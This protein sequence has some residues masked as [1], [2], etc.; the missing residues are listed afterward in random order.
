VVEKKWF[1]YGT[2][3]CKSGAQAPHSKVL[4]AWLK[5]GTYLGEAKRGYL[6][7]PRSK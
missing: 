5:P 7:M 6:D 3:N 2:C 4:R 1:V